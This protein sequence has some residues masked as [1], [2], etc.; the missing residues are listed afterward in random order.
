MNK[1]YEKFKIFSTLY[2]INLP[3]EIKRHPTTISYERSPVTFIFDNW[4]IFH[5]SDPNDRSIRIK[6]KPTTLENPC[7]LNFGSKLEVIDGKINQERLAFWEQ[8]K[9]QY[10][11][12]IL[13][14]QEENK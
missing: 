11:A 1:E 12:D 3:I 2:R 5:F 6:W 9:R 13:D 14:N 4:L 8:L 10:C 7:H